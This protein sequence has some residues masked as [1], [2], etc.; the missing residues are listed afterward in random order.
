[1]KPALFNFLPQNCLK[2]GNHS[3]CCLCC[4]QHGQDEADRTQKFRYWQILS[5]KFMSLNLYTTGTFCTAQIDRGQ[6]EH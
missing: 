6:T 3:P 2:E 5:E 4:F 1:M